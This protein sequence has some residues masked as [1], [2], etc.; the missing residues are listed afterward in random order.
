MMYLFFLK[1]TLVILVMSNIVLAI[2]KVLT[3]RQVI[4]TT[5]LVLVLS[6]LLSIMDYAILQ[7]TIESLTKPLRQQI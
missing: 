6:L 3:L 1:L 4:L 5:V 2:G 7:M